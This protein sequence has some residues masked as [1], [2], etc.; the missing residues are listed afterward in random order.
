MSE[1]T[2]PAGDSRYAALTDSAR[3]SRSGPLQSPA[4]L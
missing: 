4:I 1:R 2:G 3:K